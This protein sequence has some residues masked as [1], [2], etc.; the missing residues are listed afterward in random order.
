MSWHISY[1]RLSRVVWISD[2]RG[3][4]VARTVC[5]RGKRCIDAAGELLTEHG[6][7]RT[8]DYL[9]VGNASPVRV[10]AIRAV[11]GLVSRN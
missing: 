4:T 10:A 8:G 11:N 3:D 7:M 9:L 6:Y 1:N 5:Q 2:E